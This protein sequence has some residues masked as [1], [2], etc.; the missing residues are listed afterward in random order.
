M[1]WNFSANLELKRKDKEIKD[2]TYDYIDVKTSEEAI[3]LLFSTK[4]NFIFWYDNR[5]GGNQGRRMFFKAIRR[6]KYGKFRY[7]GNWTKPEV[8]QDELIIGNME[9]KHRDLLRKGVLSH[10]KRF[11]NANIRLKGRR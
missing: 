1:K 5:L 2:K 6:A 3:D 9:K 8:K 11:P 10:L 7:S 4:G